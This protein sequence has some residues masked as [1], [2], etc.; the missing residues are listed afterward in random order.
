MKMECSV[1][2]TE[3]RLE[4]MYNKLINQDDNELSTEDHSPHSHPPTRLKSIIGP[5]VQT[6]RVTAM[7]LGVLCAILIATIIA[8]CVRYNGLS[9]KHVVLSQNSSETHSNLQQ[10]QDRYDSITAT[11]MK[12]QKN[13]QEAV[14]A[15]D[16]MQRE[17]DR[18]KQTKDLVMREKEVLMKEETKLLARITELGKNCERCPVGWELQNTTCYLFSVAD[19]DQRLSWSQSR[20]ECRKS[21]A[22]LVVIDSQEKQEFVSRTM[23]RIGTGSRYWHI[24][25]YWI[26]LRDVHTEG[27]WKWLNGTELTRGFW[28]D[29][30]PNDQYST[31]DCAATYPKDNLLKTWNDAP[32]GYNLKWICEKN[33]R[34]N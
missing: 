29:G 4:D 21:G 1:V 10:L 25:G 16:Q 26:G 5:S 18:E 6:Y 9:E 31:E 27:V 28:L 11:L 2:H 24:T 14:S 32:C 33:V 15:K 3:N 13:F 20:E 34:E 22:D 17:R 7:I 30:E 12:V 8:L 19:S 23:K